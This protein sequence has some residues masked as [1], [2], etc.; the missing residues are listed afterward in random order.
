MEKEFLESLGLNEETVAAI[1]E[2]HGQVVSA[3]QEDMARLRFDTQVEKAVNAAG[4][5][6]LTAI[7]ALLDEQALQT[8]EDTENAIT[9]AVKDVKKQCAYL[10][11]NP[12]P[13]AYAV[14]TGTRQNTPADEPKSLADALREKF[15]KK[16]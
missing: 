2:R 11:E 8:A 10:F 5:R 3:H 9:Q 1:L 16:S 12:M 6:N 7:R 15:K 14:F 13:P 4:G